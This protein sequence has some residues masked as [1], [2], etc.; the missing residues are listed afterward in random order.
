MS[1]LRG[2]ALALLLSLVLT[3][4]LGL[5]ADDLSA[6]AAGSHHE[7]GLR[8]QPSRGWR[9]VPAA[10][11]RPPQVPAAVPVAT[12]DAPQPARTLPLPARAPF[13]PP[14]G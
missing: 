14:R 11:E 7:S 13:V 6:S 4:V 5:A 3:P 12:L 1:P 8:H 9:T 10:V 2:V